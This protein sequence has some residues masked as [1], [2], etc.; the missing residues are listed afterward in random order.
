MRNIHLKNEIQL[1]C[2]RRIHHHEG[3]NILN[4][5]LYSI[6]KAITCSG[7]F[8]ERLVVVKG[9]AIYLRDLFFPPSLNT[10]QSL[11]LNL[12]GRSNSLANLMLDVLTPIGI[13]KQNR[14]NLN[15]KK[16]LRE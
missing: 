7:P 14:K 6:A 11:I 15:V 3:F 16:E 13:P 4:S 8:M 5:R 12:F 1:I 2:Q 10:C 9:N